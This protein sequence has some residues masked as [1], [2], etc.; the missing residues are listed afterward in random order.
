MNTLMHPLH[1]EG[2]TAA[3]QPRDGL[4][5]VALQLLTNAE[6]DVLVVRPDEDFTASDVALA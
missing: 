1:A 5:S 6:C 2:G 4:E 3:S